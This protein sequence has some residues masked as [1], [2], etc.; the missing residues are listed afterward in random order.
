MEDELWDE[1]CDPDDD[2]S[3]DAPWHPDAPHINEDICEW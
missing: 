2:G 1:Y 3:D